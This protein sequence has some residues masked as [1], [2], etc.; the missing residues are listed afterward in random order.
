MM[1]QNFGTGPYRSIFDTVDDASKEQKQSVGSANEILE[2]NSAK[3]AKKASGVNFNAESDCAK[4][5]MGA[6]S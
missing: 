1:Y 2:P 6:I 4:T 3:R 5:D